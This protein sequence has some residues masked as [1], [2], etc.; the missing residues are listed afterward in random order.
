MYFVYCTLFTVLY[1]VV[2]QRSTVSRGLSVLP[3]LTL[4]P[5]LLPYLPL[6]PLLPLRPHPSVSCRVGCDRGVYMDMMDDWLK[7][8]DNLLPEMMADGGWGR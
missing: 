1:K 6:P 3:Y 5:P 7:N 2:R 8:F 4:P